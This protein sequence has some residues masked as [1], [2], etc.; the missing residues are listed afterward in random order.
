MF[1]RLT[2]KSEQAKNLRFGVQILWFDL[3]KAICYL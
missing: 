1:S 3:W 2:E